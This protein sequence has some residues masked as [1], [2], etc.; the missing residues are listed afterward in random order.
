MIS[1][2]DFLATLAKL[3]AIAGGGSMVLFDPSWQSFLS[4][5]NSGLAFGDTYLDELI[6]MAPRARY[7]KPI[8][9]KGDRYSP[10]ETIA[11][12]LLC[13]KGCAITNGQKGRCR[14]PQGRITRRSRLPAPQR[15]ASPSPRACP[16]TR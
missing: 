11:R 2:R 12:C 15:C 5:S 14:T 3:A 1:R 13:A 9:V 7:W 16:S 8:T 6:R 10:D 4:G